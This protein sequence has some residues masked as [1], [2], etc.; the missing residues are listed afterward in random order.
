MRDQCT[1][2]AAV[3]TREALRDERC[4]VAVTREDRVTNRN[5]RPRSARHDSS[6]RP[7]GDAD[8]DLY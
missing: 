1:L 3:E 2:S 4:S 7:T 6:F 8:H 5:V